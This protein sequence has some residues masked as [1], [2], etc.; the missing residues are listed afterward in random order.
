MSELAKSKSE[1]ACHP[2]SGPD[3]ELERALFRVLKSL[4]FRSHPSRS[5]LD[6]LPITQLRCLHVIHHQQGLRMVEVSQRL[7]TKLPAISQIVD[8]LV[9]RGMVERRSDPNDRRVVRLFLTNE[10]Q[11]IMEEADAVRQAR[12]N[13]TAALLNERSMR[14]VVNGLEL[15]ADAAE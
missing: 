3:S 15:L 14:S 12:M 13:A 5:A 9:K 4:I 6:E 7:E 1:S 11:A 8:R 10:A 2:G